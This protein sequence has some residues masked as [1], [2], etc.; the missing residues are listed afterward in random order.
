MRRLL[1]PGNLVASAI[2]VAVATMVVVAN[3][4]DVR[5]GRTPYSRPELAGTRGARTSRE[6]LD[7][8]VSDLR[9]KLAER[10]LDVGVAIMLGDTLLRQARTTG[11][12]G[13]AIEAE[14]AMMT[15][16]EGDVANYDANRLLATIYLSQHRFRDAIAMADRSRAARPDDPINY[17]VLGDGHLELGDY[18]QAFDAFDRMMA[19]RPSA[20]AYA[21]VAY[22]RELQGNLTGAIE[23]MRL[24]AEAT[25]ADD[26]ESLA[27]HRAQIGDLYFRLNRP[28][29]AEAEYIAASQ[30]FPG[31]PFAV[32]GYARVV[33][34]RGDLTGALSLLRDL[35][36]RSGTPDLA[37]RIG[38]LYEQMGRHEEAERQYALAESG[39]R[40]DAPE[41][42]NLAR[43]L[44]D[45]GRKL[46]EAVTIAQAAAAERHDIFTSD[47]LAWAY[48]KIGR[49]AEARQAI[50]QALRTGTRDADILAHAAAIAGPGARQVA[51]R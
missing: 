26:P 7:R 28:H 23:A 40:V 29:E 6:D 33:A 27:W 22:A 42:K 36:S 39:W 16:L 11:N 45:H 10:P 38:D 25:A 9:K 44:A 51:S 32:T 31:H 3:L 14:R 35:Q 20:A 41:P 2:I 24:A 21:R 34:A 49:H 43:F 5:R 18:D 8:R 13:L 37:A 50:A 12:A 17:G 19:L 30:A 4:R 1:T 48:Y 15:A 47:A 46:S